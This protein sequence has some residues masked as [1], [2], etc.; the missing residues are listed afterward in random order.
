ME[1]QSVYCEVEACFHCIIYV[2]IGVQGRAMTPAVSRR[3]VIASSRVQSMVS[4]C[5]ICGWQWHCAGLSGRAVYR[6]RLRPLVCWGC[7]FESHVGARTLLW[8]LFVVRERSL[9]RADHS[10]R[11]ILPTVVRRCV[12]SRNLVN[13]LAPELFFLILAHP[14]YK[15]WIIHEPNTLE[16]WNKLHFEEEKNWD[17][18]PCLKY[19]VPIFV[20]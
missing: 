3:P 20:E 1:M 19:S 2:C 13:L 14:V 15:M 4:P 10:S 5:E 17:Y 18:I 11:G 16:L 7:A 9:R 6:T 8:V 12:W